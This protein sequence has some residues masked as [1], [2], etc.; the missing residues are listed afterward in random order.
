MKDHGIYLDF[1]TCIHEAIEKHKTRKDPIPVDAAQQ[2][3]EEKFRSIHKTNS[4]RYKLR[5]RE[6]DVE[7][8]V[9]AGKKIL[10][11]LQACDELAQA[12]VVY[13]EYKL[14]LPIERSDDVKI[15]FKG[16][17]DMVIRS[18]D[19]LGKQVLYVVDFK[20]CSWGWD[21][22]K[23]QD[24]E[25]QYQLFLYKHFL[26]KKFDL[27]PKHVK[28]AFILLK[29]APRKGTVAVEFFPVSAG[30]VS[31]QKT[32]DAMNSDL[33]DMD[34]RLR[35]GTLQKNRKACVNDFGDTCPYYKTDL[36]PGE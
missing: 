35:D 12:E 32:L 29:R 9:R 33:T 25:L 17:I 18:K 10:E 6:I 34:S 22:Q 4:F 24:K 11:H 19:K 3:F 15:E 30:P 7:D 26:C 2:L 27:D 8:F 21:Q 13:N 31:V 1:G 36:C 23:K 20:T 28:T 14:Q 16:Y 5:E